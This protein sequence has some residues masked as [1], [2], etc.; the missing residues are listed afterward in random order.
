M[1]KIVINLPNPMLASN[2]CLPHAA[3][4]L[5]SAR[6]VGLQPRPGMV[7]RLVIQ[8]Q[9]DAWC[10]FRLDKD[11]GFVGESWHPTKEDA[12]YQAKK[13]FGIESTNLHE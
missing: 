11:G 12:L 6:G 9:L 13:E 3:M 2:D 5:G 1:N 7:S 10:F 4:N 8:S